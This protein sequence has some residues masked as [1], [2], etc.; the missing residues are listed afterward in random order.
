MLARYSMNFRAAGTVRSERTWRAGAAFGSDTGATCAARSSTVTLRRTRNSWRP[1]RAIRQ[2]RAAA[3]QCNA[4]VEIKTSA[5]AR[6]TRECLTLSIARVA[7]R[8]W[9]PPT[10][11]S[12]RGFCPCA[13]QQ[14]QARPSG[15]GPQDPQR[16]HSTLRCMGP[17]H[18]GRDESHP[19]RW[20]AFRGCVRGC[21]TPRRALGR[22]QS[23]LH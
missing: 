3:R 10:E 14:C 18:G 15:A 5:K 12:H 19:A 6:R 16:V 21:V 13:V 23:T 17:A 7:G 4:I 2:A 1:S 9:S 20:G 22:T 11:P 8:R